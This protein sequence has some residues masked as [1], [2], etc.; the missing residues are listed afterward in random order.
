MAVP[1]T[2]RCP[3]AKTCGG[4][5]NCECC[6][7]LAADAVAH[8]VG[9]RREVPLDSLSELVERVVGCN[10]RYTETI[11]NRLKDKTRILN[12][13][14]V[15]IKT[16]CSV[17]L[18]LEK[19]PVVV[20]DWLAERGLPESLA[21]ELGRMSEIG[22]VNFF[23]MQTKPLVVRAR[24]THNAHNIETLEIQVRKAGPTGIKLAHLFKEYELAC[25]DI[26][27]AR[28]RIAIVGNRAYTTEVASPPND[29]LCSIFGITPVQNLL[30]TP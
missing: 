19:D 6:I 23:R 29:W 12:D 3:G 26:V 30:L 8:E 15:P 1:Y 21:S 22:N 4:Y 16:W 9:R 17:Q 20:V 13:A 10:S 27:A 11:K 5:F 14:V 25:A 28:D 2:L 18:G 7:N 24:T